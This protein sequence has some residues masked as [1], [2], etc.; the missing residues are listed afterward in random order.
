MLKFSPEFFDSIVFSIKLSVV[1]EPVDA[2]VAAH[3]N[4]FRV[5]TMVVSP[6][7]DKVMP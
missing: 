3:T 2:S 6:L 4:I 7:R 5:L 1:E